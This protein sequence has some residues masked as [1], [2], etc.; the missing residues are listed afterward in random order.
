MKGKFLELHLK[1]NS[2]NPDTLRVNKN[3]VSGNLNAFEFQDANT[4]QFIFYFPAL[5]ISGYG[6]TKEKAFEIAEFSISEYFN[7]L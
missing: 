4:G 3:H 5:D 7:Y 6:D 1:E 2:G